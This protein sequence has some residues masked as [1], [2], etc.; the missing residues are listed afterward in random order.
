MH[1]V[2][3]NHATLEQIYSQFLN[4]NYFT[5]FFLNAPKHSI[6]FGIYQFVVIFNIY[7]TI[8]VPL[9]VYQNLK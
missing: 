2:T 4:K 8:D 1:Q 7:F 3:S 9:F 5:L 6:K